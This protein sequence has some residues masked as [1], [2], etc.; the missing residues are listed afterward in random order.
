LEKLKVENKK[1]EEKKPE[2]SD[3]KPNFESSDQEAKMTNKISDTTIIPLPPFDE[4]KP[5][6]W[7]TIV[8]SKFKT[9]GIPETDYYKRV[10]MDIP[11]RIVEVIPGITEPS[12]DDDKW[13]YFEK[14]IKEAFGKS[15]EQEIRDLLRKSNHLQNPRRM[16]DFMID[17]AG[18]DVTPRV[19]AD[20]YRSSL[21][22]DVARTILT[23]PSKNTED[24]RAMAD[25]A[26]GV[27]DFEKERSPEKNIIASI[28]SSNLVNSDTDELKKLWKE[29]KDLKSQIGQLL[30]HQNT[31]QN[32]QYTHNSHSNQRSYT[33]Q[34][35]H[36]SDNRQNRSRSRNRSNPKPMIDFNDP[37]NKGKCEYHIRYGDNAWHCTLPCIDSDKPLKTKPQRASRPNNNNSN[38]T[39]SREGQ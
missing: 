6:V 10:R 12:T 20:L 28:S 27:F 15:R 11:P 1:P 29:V 4:E 16:M 5:H 31:T 8:K 24:L 22:R 35:S 30:K 18:D 13:D 23:L 38:T 33:N 17:K 19:I 7:L 37:Q 21:P 36:R 34:N 9:L 14:K 32:T 26:Q 39:N 25:V 2:N 3:S